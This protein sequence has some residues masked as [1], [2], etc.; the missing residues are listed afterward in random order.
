MSKKS[1]SPLDVYG[2]LPRTNCKECG[3]PNCMAFATK[4]INREVTLEE[5]PPLKEEKYKSAYAKLWDLLKPPV[6]EVTIGVADQA[7]KIGGKY[8]MYR[9]ELT[10]YNPAAIAIDITD[11]TPEDEL[12][13]RV[14][15]IEGFSFEY[16]GQQLRLDLVAVRSVSNDPSKF[17]SAVENIVGSTPLPLILCSFNPD[18]IEG[19]LAAAGGRRPLVYAANKDNWREMA[20]MALAH[21]CPLSV[22]AP[23]DLR[24][25]R[26][27]TRTLTDYG[28]ED[29]VLDPGTF[30]DHGLG[31]T[32]NN[33]T[34]IRRAACKEGDSLFGFPLMG[35]PIVA[36]TEYGDVPEIAAWKEVCLAAML[37]T[38]YADLIVMHSLEGWAL[39]PTVIFRQNLYTDPRKP[40]SVEPGLRKFGTPDEASPVMLTTNFALTYYT[41]ASDIES[42]GVSGYLLVVDTEGISVESAVAGR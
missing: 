18:V 15:G 28:V 25:L 23:N 24:L 27:L 31:D 39:L 33:F 36:W 1:I 16:I 19:A 42:S 37:I 14:K 35:T 11:E 41:V 22:Y 17:G 10:Y 26:S 9:H 38:R 29:L 34:L 32:V 5:C 20:D 13:K 2:L 30:V 3:E 4:L 40:V 7:L 21:N 8:V 6:K 12:M